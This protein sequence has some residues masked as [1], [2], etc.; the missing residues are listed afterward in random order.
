MRTERRRRARPPG[1]RPAR[2]APGPSPPEGRRR[3]AASAWREIGGKYLQPI[4]LGS[5]TRVARWPSD[6]TWAARW[7]GGAA[8]AAPR[9]AVR[10][11]RR[12]PPPRA[13]PP[14][15]PPSCPPSRPDRPLLGTARASPPPGLPPRFP[16]RDA[17]APR[18]GRSP[19]PLRRPLR[20]PSPGSPRGPC[21]AADPCLGD[22][23]GGSAVPP[24]PRRPRRPRS[25]A[26]PRARPRPRRT[27]KAARAGRPR[28]PLRS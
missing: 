4:R 25:P 8:R 19:W 22:R 20:R 11:A 21:T 3:V 9:A 18:F 13:A 1:S 24:R 7:G 10:T 28:I 16:R 6:A 14:P 27:P 2:K 23:S 26:R 12:L 5:R 15:P 17:R